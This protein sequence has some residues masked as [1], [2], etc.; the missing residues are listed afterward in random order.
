[1]T[2][3]G[4]TS[5]QKNRRLLTD[6]VR[7]EI[8]GDLLSGAYSPG[9]KLP[10]EPE[11]AR[12]YGVSR[13]TL[14]EAVRGLVEEGYL[15][16]RHGLGTYVTRKPK[17]RN[18]MDVN[19]GV[20]DLIKSMGLTPGN[21]DVRVREEAATEPVARAMSLETGEPVAH[22]E[23]IRTADG[24]P[25]VF[26]VEFVPAA[27]LER[28][29]DDLRDLSGSLYEFLAS[30]GSPVNHGVATIVPEVA[31]REM[32]R[33]LGV[34]P[35]APLLHVTQVDYGPGDRPVLYSLEWYRAE[36]LEV[37]VYRK[38]PTLRENGISRP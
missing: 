29:A 14:R 6:V 36:E 7:D 18:N 28:G 17:L 2:D 4:R 1:M 21:A 24:E 30:I 15:S 22:L 13:I 26:S 35:G 20:T 23:R 10:P 12:A 32:A 31:D 19:F 27:L 8:R 3:L 34:R 38:G 5:R 11:L 25:I 9:D 16:R 33:R 37:T